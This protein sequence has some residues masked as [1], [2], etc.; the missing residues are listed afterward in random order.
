MTLQNDSHDPVPDAVHPG[1]APDG[2]SLIR[3]EGIG[4]SFPGVRALD[5]VEFEVRV[6]EVHALVGENGSGKSTLMKIASG[7]VRPDEGRILVRGEEAS[8]RGPADAIAAGVTLTVQE[9]ALVPDLT[10]AENVLLGRLPK[11]RLRI[12]WSEAR[13]QAS[14]VLAELEIDVDPMRFAGQLSLDVQQMVSIA[15]SLSQ[16]PRLLI[17]D[18]A[19]SSLTEDQVEALFRAIRRLRDDGTSVVFISHRLREIYSVADR[20]TVLRDG[21]VVGTLPIGV[22]DQARVTSMM[23]GR[24]LVDYFGKKEIQR[25]PVVLSVRDVSDGKLLRDVSFDVHSREIVGLAG[26]VGAGRTE[27]LRMLFGMH[28]IVAGQISIDGAPVRIREPRD[29]IGHGLAL[30]PED[31]RRSG[32]VPMLSLRENLGMAAKA[33]ITEGFVV[34]RSE[35]RALASKYVDRLR[36]KSTS[37]ETPVSMLSGGNQQKVVVGKWMAVDPRI[38]L[39]DEPTR[40]V[41]VGAKAEIH[42]LLSDLS[43]SGMGILMSSSELTDLLGVCDRVLVMFR[44]RLVA[45]LPRSEATE[46]RVIYFATG[47]GQ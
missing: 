6:G 11:K 27:L 19:T 38:W 14:A 31:R 8:F 10:V 13:R 9:V 2:T 45:D 25:G 42:R 35:E 26:L 37:L 40:G 5:G 15:K 33:R 44:G 36:I 12:D 21:R 32:L 17:L 34:R 29:A 30:V 46:E 20:V 18:E 43:A 47:Q 1:E 7:E 39:L 3:M 28:H 4:K 23:V 16:R 24:E 22:A 41:D